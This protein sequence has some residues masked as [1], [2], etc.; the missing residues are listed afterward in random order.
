MQD[1]K[2]RN[3]TLDVYSS[4]KV[5]G[6]EFSENNFK[7]GFLKQSLEFKKFIKGKKIQNNI[8]FGKE[9]I[10]FIE[11]ILIWFFYEHTHIL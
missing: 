5:Y 1:I 6:N 4:S 10:K 11:K 7:P 8:Y 2:D 9:I 3:I